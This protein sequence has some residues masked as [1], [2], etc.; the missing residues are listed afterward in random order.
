[1]RY[2]SF[3]ADTVGKHGRRLPQIAQF[4][5]CRIGDGSKGDA[6]PA[7]PHAAHGGKNC[8]LQERGVGIVGI[9]GRGAGEFAGGHYPWADGL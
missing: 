8:M 1:M 5:K 9:E 4:Q 7:E 6:A 2:K 3:V